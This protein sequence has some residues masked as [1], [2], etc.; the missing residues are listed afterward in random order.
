ME[1]TFNHLDLNLQSGVITNNGYSIGIYSRHK[2]RLVIKNDY[3]MMMKN[4]PTLKKDFEKSVI[5]YVVDNEILSSEGLD[6]VNVECIGVSYMED[7][8]MM[9]PI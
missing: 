7:D 4:S 5:N 9:K 2:N 6:L 3:I 1:S 8:Y